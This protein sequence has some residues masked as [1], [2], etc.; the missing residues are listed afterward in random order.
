MDRPDP[1][2]EISH[3]KPRTQ[4]EFH[5]NQ[6]K[7]KQM[8]LNQLKTE[9]TIPYPITHTNDFNPALDEETSTQFGNDIKS[10]LE[11]YGV[12]I[13]SGFLPDELCDAYA[14]ESVE[15]LIE[16]EPALDIE[17]Y[18]TWTSVNTPHGPR[19]GMYQTIVGQFEV[20]W[21]LR[22]H[23][24]HI[25]KA[26]YGDEDLLTSVDGASVFPPRLELPA[27]KD[28]AH[29]DSAVYDEISYQG[30]IVLTDTTAAFRCTPMS[31]TIIPQL[32]ELNIIK[33]NR[34][35]NLIGEKN[36]E[37]VKQLLPYPE[38]YQI[39]L[40]VPKGSFILWKSQT[41]H[42]ACR[43]TQLI[44]DNSSPLVN[45]RCVF[46]ICMMPREH[47]SQ[48]DIRNL[49]KAV[50]EGYLTNHNASSLFSKIQGPRKRS[51]NVSRA[52]RN[53]SKFT[54]RGFIAQSEILRTVTDMK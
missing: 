52:L 9:I 33:T 6:N 44:E 39:P 49:H 35:F 31:H 41:I 8:D 46:Y 28:W 36:I 50:A 47:Y 3:I 17:D 42:S 30:Q 23:S 5:T 40:A 12:C 2:R 15:K 34:G 13:I 43:Q 16:I 29:V 11:Q 21:K 4:S 25:F 19:R 22:E 51:D 27:V 45:W 18:N 24:Y 10:L 32:V 54:Q 7:P 37:I 14:M 26:I 38:L 48:E 20:A 53:L 1:T